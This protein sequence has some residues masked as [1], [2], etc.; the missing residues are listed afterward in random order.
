MSDLLERI[1]NAVLGNITWVVFAVFLLSGFLGKGGKRDAD[2]QE[3][4]PRQQARR[5]SGPQSGKRPFAE[6]MAEA[7][8]MEEVVQEMRRAE[9][10]EQSAPRQQ[11]RQQRRPVFA[12]DARRGTTARSVQEQYPELFGGPSLFDDRDDEFGGKTKWGFDETEWG[13][14]F[15]KNDEQWGSSFGDRRDSEPRIEWP[16]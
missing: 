3:S 5:H 12:S 9:E 7:L 2:Q 4:K 15:E 16:K 14:T 6:R 8:G 11:Q 13:T 10:N 1:I